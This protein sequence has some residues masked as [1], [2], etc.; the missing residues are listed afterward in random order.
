MPIAPKEKLTEEELK[1]LSA[2]ELRAKLSDLQLSSFGY[3]PQ[4]IKRLVEAYQ[5]VPDT[6]VAPAAPVAVAGRGGG[7]QGAASRGGIASMKVVDLRKELQIRNL[8]TNGSKK[9]LVNRLQ[10]GI[11]AEKVVATEKSAQSF[12]A[13][14]A[15]LAASPFKPAAS[16]D[17]AKFVTPTKHQP[18]E[19]NMSDPTGTPTTTNCTTIDTASSDAQEVASLFLKIFTTLAQGDQFDVALDNLITILVKAQRGQLSSVAVDLSNKAAGVTVAQAITASAGGGLGGTTDATAAQ[20]AD[21]SG[22]STA[23]IQGPFVGGEKVCCI[24]DGPITTVA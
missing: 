19:S 1:R 3:R 13:A 8:P 10:D 18:A 23:Q 20:T 7:G 16:A 24:C 5:E 4:L 21:A 17:S 22:A 12:G 6:A 14:S 11:A 2:D 15:K 9:D